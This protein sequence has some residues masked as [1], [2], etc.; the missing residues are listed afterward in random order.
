MLDCWKLEPDSRPSF[1][2][3]VPLLSEF[4]E[5]MIGYMDAFVPDKDDHESSIIKVS[6]SENI[7]SDICAETI[8]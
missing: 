1:S 5:V 6:L 2:D 8:M 4:L 3:L 7:L